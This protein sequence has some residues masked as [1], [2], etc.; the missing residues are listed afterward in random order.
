[1]K[2]AGNFPSIPRVTSHQSS[3]L[4][5]KKWCSTTSV[6]SQIWSRWRNS[7]FYRRREKCHRVS[8]QRLDEMQMN[9]TSWYISCSW[10]HS[11]L[12]DDHQ[13]THIS[14]SNWC[15]NHR[16]FSSLANHFFI[17]F[18]NRFPFLHRF[19]EDTWPL[20]FFLGINI[21]TTHFISRTSACKTIGC[22]HSH[23]LK[24]ATF[25]TRRS[26]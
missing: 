22:R 6:T 15:D 14:I 24:T 21:E 10:I 8:C 2:V 3:I 9:H 4:W 13:P 16:N 19:K 7:S 12:N 1:M 23:N 20:L 17:S 5:T 11:K 26:S 25:Y 18:L